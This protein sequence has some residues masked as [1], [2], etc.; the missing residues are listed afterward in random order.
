VN[1]PHI[2]RRRRRERGAGIMETMIGILIGLLVVLVVYNLLAVAEDYR[3]ATTG[4]SD[5]QITGLLSQFVTSQDAA[6]AGSGLLSGFDDLVTCNKTEADGA[7]TNDMGAGP[8]TLKPIPIIVYKGA[9]AAD[10]DSFVTRISGSPHVIWPLD[11]RVPSPLAGQNITVSSPLGFST[12]AGASLPTAANP[13]WA[14][15]IA[16]DG[17]GRCALHTRASARISADHAACR[18]VSG[19]TGSNQRSIPP[20]SALY[21]S[22]C[23]CIRCGT[24]CNWSSSAIKHACRRL[25]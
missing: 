9:T 7:F 23:Q 19:N 2:T 13:F 10:S 17:T 5:A 22:G 21:S 18:T 14:I 3:R 8:A 24:C 20:C 16:N 11:F 6:S 1:R 4:A 25:R 12:V 15:A